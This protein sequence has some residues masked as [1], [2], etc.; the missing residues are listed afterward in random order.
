MVSKRNNYYL[1]R[2]SFDYGTY[3]EV[4]S[5]LFFCGLNNLDVR[6]STRI[7]EAKRYSKENAIKLLLKLNSTVNDSNEFKV[8]RFKNNVFEL[9]P[10]PEVDATIEFLKLKMI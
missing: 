8:V 9:V 1:V 6:M 10:Q 5:L 2:L 3:Y 7:Y 4:T